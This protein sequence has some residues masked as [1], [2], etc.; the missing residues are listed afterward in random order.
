VPGRIV[1][2]LVHAAL[3][4]GAVAA[5]FLVL[6]MGVAVVLIMAQ[7][8]LDQLGADPTQAVFELLGAGG[9]GVLTAIQ[10]IGLGA[11]A[12][13]LC[14]VLPAPSEVAPRVLPADRATT[15]ERLR[16]GLALRL[17]HPVWVAAAAIGGLTVWTFP[18]WLAEQLMTW[19]PDSHSAIEIVS[20]LLANSAG[21]GRVA[22]VFAIVVTAPLFEELVFRGY[23]WR[24]V[25]WIAP[26]WVALVVTTVLFAAFHMDAVHSIALLPTALYLGW[27][28][29]R[30]G[31]IL[32]GIVAHFVNNGVGVVAGILAPAAEAT[33]SLP[34]AWALAGAAFTVAVSAAAA[35]VVRRSPP[36]APTV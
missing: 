5:W 29:L 8:P 27:L 6:G 13:A 2:L 17:S 12:A 11:I 30:S 28:R 20:E 33:D 19:F 7:V 21:P 9:A 36:L 10:T 15:T 34:L 1:Y 14:L 3:F 18:T 25:C 22:I 4:L 26:G 31:S 23:L 32:P 24:L 16:S 35:M